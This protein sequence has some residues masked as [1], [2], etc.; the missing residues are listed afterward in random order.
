MLTMVDEL[1]THPDDPGEP[2]H[3][4]KR[5]GIAPDEERIL[6]ALAR[7]RFVLEIGT[8]L[9]YSTRALAS[10]ASMV[11]SVD[12]DPWV[13]D[14]I[15]PDLRG[16][17]VSCARDWP[18][19]RGFD[20]VFIDGDHRTPAVEGDVQ[21]ALA[22]ARPGGIILLHDYQA[23]PEV[24]EGARRATDLPVTEI[25]TTYGLGLIVKPLTEGA[26]A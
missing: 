1:R 20:L 12:P 6:Q 25:R 21:R 11:F 10:S 16:L 7:R 3:G 15:V 2:Q 18:S 19:I 23:D 22:V 17:M 9:G 24:R 8:G 26:G 4:R 5:V 14:V 13:H